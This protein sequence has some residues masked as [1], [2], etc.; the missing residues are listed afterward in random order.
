[1]PQ[2]IDKDVLVAEIIKRRA[3]RVEQIKIGDD[4]TRPIDG[5]VSVE[6]TSLL[7]FVDTLEIKEVELENVK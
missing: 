7:D 4:R 2:Y 3:E 5:A 1:M 6:H